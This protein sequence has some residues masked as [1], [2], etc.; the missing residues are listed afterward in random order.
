MSFLF[1]LLFSLLLTILIEV[2]VAVVLKIRTVRDVCVVIVAQILTNPVVNIGSLF[3]A[4]L[5]SSYWYGLYLFIIET[6]VLFVES[7]IYKS[8]LQNKRVSPFRLSYL[9]NLTS[10]GIGIV[11]VL[12]SEIWY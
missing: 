6:I 7:F 11:Y 5:N 9:C 3:V 12:I 8:C 1:Y 4:I 10:F 2:I